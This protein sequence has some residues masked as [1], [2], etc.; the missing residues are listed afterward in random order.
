MVGVA[1]ISAGQGRGETTSRPQCWNQSAPGASRWAA[2]HLSWGSRGRTGGPSWTDRGLL[3]GLCSAH[4]GLSPRM[5]GH[6]H[7]S[8]LRKEKEA[9]P[10]NRIQLA[11]KQ[12]K[13]APLSKSG[14]LQ[15]TSR[16]CTLPGSHTLLPVQVHATT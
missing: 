14:S 4:R 7:G 2:A 12:N 5:L 6:L 15:A 9:V 16:P 10:H 1:L 11:N 8:E 3:L 13:I